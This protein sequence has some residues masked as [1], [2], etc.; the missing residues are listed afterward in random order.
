L[1]FLLVAYSLAVGNAG[2]GF[3]YRS[4]LVTLAIGAVVVLRAHLVAEP[5]L[6]R[7]P[8]R[9]LRSENRRLGR[10]PSAVHEM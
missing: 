6:S 5:A 7:K 1:F 4:H 9:A 10:A 3:R 8:K 2:T